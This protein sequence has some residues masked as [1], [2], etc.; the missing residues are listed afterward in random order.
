MFYWNR[1]HPIYPYPRRR[2]FWTCVLC[3]CF[4]WHPSPFNI[5]VSSNYYNSSGSSGHVCNSCCSFNHHKLAKKS[6]SMHTIGRSSPSSCLR[7][8]WS[9]IVDSSL[10]WSS[11]PIIYPPCAFCKLCSQVFGSPGMSALIFSTLWAHFPWCCG[12]CKG[13]YILYSIQHK[14]FGLYASSAT[15]SL[16]IV[17]GEVYC[18]G[19]PERNAHWMLVMVSF[20]LFACSGCL[21]FELVTA[22]VVARVIFILWTSRPLIRINS[23]CTEYV[24]RNPDAKYESQAIHFPKEITT[25]FCLLR[26]SEIRSNQKTRVSRNSPIYKTTWLKV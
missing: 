8:P 12:L 18:E 9:R 3:L 6:T 23:I 13:L 21:V 24:C 16:H 11:R 1:W 20:S 14:V 7:G 26:W 2:S 19:N 22:P 4:S 10:V 17:S 25:V 5:A 15:S